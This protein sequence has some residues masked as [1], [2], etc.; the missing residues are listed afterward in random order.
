[1]LFRS[2]TGYG[3]PGYY[4]TGETQGTIDRSGLVGI[5]PTGQFFITLGT[6]AAALS[7]S[8]ALVGQVTEGLDVAKTLTEVAPGDPASPTPDMVKDITIVEK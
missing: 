4:C 8:F 1:M 7:G 2:G 5:T 3:H 6:D